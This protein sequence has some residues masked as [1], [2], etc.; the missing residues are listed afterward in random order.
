MRVL[1]VMFI[2]VW[3]GYVEE[4]NLYIFFFFR[5]FIVFLIGV[6]IVFF[7][8]IVVLKFFWVCNIIIG[9]LIFGN[10]VYLRLVKVNNFVIVIVN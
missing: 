1:K 8:F 4:C 3:F 6:V 5:I 10:K 9:K 7:V 2:I